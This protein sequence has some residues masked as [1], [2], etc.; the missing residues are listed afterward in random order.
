MA[1]SAFA[2]AVRIIFLLPF[3]FSPQPEEE[4]QAATTSITQSDST[5]NQSEELTAQRSPSE[6]ER[7]AI[8][9]HNSARAFPL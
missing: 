4:L 2:V 1:S 3:L 9:E 5:N 6:E 7:E 8:S